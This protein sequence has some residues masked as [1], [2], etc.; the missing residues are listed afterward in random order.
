MSILII[1][2]RWCLLGFSSVKL[3]FKKI[4]VIKYFVSGAFKLCK[5][6]IPHQALNLVVYLYL[7]GLRYPVFSIGHSTYFEAQIGTVWATGCPF[8][9]ASAFF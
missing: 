1:L 7:Y 8:T 2:L 3:P 5:Y 4:F 6:A 9:L